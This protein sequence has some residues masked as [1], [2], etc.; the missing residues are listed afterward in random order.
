[1]DKTAIRKFAIWARQRLIDEIIVKAQL[2]GITEKEIAEPFKTAGGLEVYALPNGETYTL[3]GGELTQ[4]RRLVEVI[5][6]QMRGSNLKTAFRNVV[7]EVA[8][9]WFNRLIAVRFMEVND[10]LDVKVLSSSN[11]K[12]E[13]DLMLDYRDIELGLNSND[14]KQLEQWQRSGKP[15]DLDNIFRLL[16]IRKCNDLNKILP[17]LFEK[18][19]DYME[20]LFSASVVNPEGII[21]HLIEDIPE[22]D[23]NVNKG[24]QVEII[25]WLYQYY[26]SEPKEQVFANLKKNIKITKENIPAATQFFTPDWIV[27]YMVENSLGRLWVSGHPNEN[28]QKGWKY[29]LPEAEQELE[30][31][32]EL[33]KL[34]QDYA[35]IKIEEIKCIDPCCGSGH[36]L[37][38]IFDLLMQIY[39]GMGYMPRDA[40][41]S[42]I[43]NNLFGLDIDKRAVQLSYFAVMMKARQYDNRAFGRHLTPKIYAVE[44]SNGITPDTILYFGK[45]KELKQALEKLVQ[46]MHDAKEYGSLV[47]VSGYNWQEIYARFEEIKQDTSLDKIYAMDMLPMVQVAEVLAQKYHVVVTNPPYMGGSG[48]AAKLS[49]YVKANFPDSKTDLFACFME[50]GNFMT[51][52]N[53][54][55]CMV[56]MQSWMFLSS[57]EAMRKKILQTKTITNLMH[58]ENMVMGIAF[59]TAVTIMQDAVI[60]GFK[61]TYNQI[62]LC[63]IENGYPKEFPVKGNRF[64]QV[65]TDNF[66]KI[67]G[68]PVAYWVGEKV[69]DCFNGAKRIG[70]IAEPKQGLATA[71]N[72]R[73]LRFWSEVRDFSLF[74]DCSSHILSKKSSQKWYPYNK[75]GGY[76]KWYGNNEFV[77]NWQ[78]DGFL[79]R[80]FMGSV[81]RSPQF[82]F[83]NC[84]SWCKITSGLFSMRYI[85]LGFLFD[86]AGCSLFADES[87]L[88]YLIGFLNSC[89]SRILLSVISP[90][91]NYEVGHIANLPVIIC[92][93]DKE[94]VDKIV[95]A[96]ISL[97]K[98]DWDMYETSWDFE[99]HPLV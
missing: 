60:A 75:G 14:L 65:S 82:Y 77:I 40:V 32:E 54:Y 49:E 96:N 63:D 35:K 44:E 31:A 95:L 86:V 20:L 93:L 61:G 26:N 43:S 45:T 4:R 90:T 36:I 8:Y 47:K 74:F 6:T 64:A 84:G 76:R 50:Q 72:S 19:D 73:F 69:I 18:T 27:R 30:A 29:Y 51:T 25:G 41:Q 80:N 71:D 2:V 15:N 97:S 22:D 83:L 13:T 24:G 11:D 28:L 37:V 34:A 38:Y 9:T 92:D 79:L 17:G 53:G 48:M 3:Q 89:V 7:E 81:I 94:S 88:F 39:D 58:M 12:V 85:P 55:N 98:T 21:R 59:G 46:E 1:M 67:P 70:E 66:S 62:K 56:T 33:Q 68:S 52:K 87:K 16:F 10:Y 91:L 57:F 78:N 42:I 23:F 5:K 99:R